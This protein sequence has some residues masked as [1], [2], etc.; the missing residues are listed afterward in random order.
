MYKLVIN[1]TLL[2]LLLHAVAM[3]GQCQP[4]KNRS[5]SSRTTPQKV[6]QDA[7]KAPLEGGVAVVA[8][9]LELLRARAAEDALRARLMQPTAFGSA[10]TNVLW[11]NG[12]VSIGHDGGRWNVHKYIPRFD[13]W[14]TT[15]APVD[16]PH[17]GNFAV[18]GKK[19]VVLFSSTR[20]W[21][22]DLQSGLW[23]SIP[24]P[25]PSRTVRYHLR[26]VGD[27]LVVWGSEREGADT[28][29]AV[30][31]PDRQKWHSLPPAPISGRSRAVHAAIGDDKFIVWGGHYPT[32]QDGAML[33]LKKWKWRKLP[34]APIVF[35]DYF[36]SDC[37][38]T[39]F[40]VVGGAKTKVVAMYDTKSN[41][42][43]VLPAPPINTGQNP[44]CAV[45][46]DK[47][48]VWSGQSSGVGTPT[49][50]FEVAVM[51]LKSMRWNVGQD[52]PM[53][54][55]WYPLS[56]PSQ[57]GIYVYSGWNYDDFYDNPGDDRFVPGMPERKWA[58][59]RSHTSGACFSFANM[60]WIPIKPLPNGTG[61]LGGLFNSW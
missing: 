51:D 18:I 31:F 20:G 21:L 26:F 32:F 57:G 14:L 36:S 27:K 40:I 53:K 47:L 38:G 46:G 7:K 1:T 58:N 2:V 11:S 25:P 19:S 37:W 22:V 23:K 44:G 49:A 52:A 9:S 42:W 43:Q 6:S 24:V 10:E 17:Q 16:E 34:P 4:R 41:R 30:F 35:T 39:K 33:D 5:A 55:R 59:A 56:C 61:T 60:S 8:P 29:G 28:G 15:R 48:T 54:T 13:L 3:P 12:P 50:R 45:S